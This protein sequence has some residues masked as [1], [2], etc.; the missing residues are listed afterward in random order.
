MEEG[1]VTF[2]GIPSRSFYNPMGTVHGGW[3]A[4]LLDTA[5]GCA[6]HSVLPA[7]TAYT[8]IE[9]KTVFVKPLREEH[10]PVTCEAVVLHRG[11]QIAG[12][13]GKLYDAKRRLIA[14]GSETCLVR[15]PRADPPA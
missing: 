3:I 2:T 11:S 10:G 5:M 1:R 4:L 8:T 12:A 6:V 14:Y 7:G 15:A 13:E 9:M